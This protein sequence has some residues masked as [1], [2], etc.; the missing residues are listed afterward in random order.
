MSD[1]EFDVLDELYFVTSFGQLCR[2]LQL[3]EQE[4]KEILRALV[5]KGWVK[6]FDGDTKEV[7]VSELSFDERY[8]QYHYLAT[9]A[10]LFAHHSR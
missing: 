2:T 3:A 1:L 5:G 10:G 7:V 4:V 8:A 9:K 6:C